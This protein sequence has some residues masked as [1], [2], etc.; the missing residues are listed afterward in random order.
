MFYSVDDAGFVSFNNDSWLQH[1][2]KR[3]MG[4]EAQLVWTKIERED[5]QV[6]MFWGNDRANCPLE[7]RFWGK[8][9]RAE[10][11]SGKFPDPH[12][13][14]QVTTCSGYDL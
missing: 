7:Q 12:A 9:V 14:L 5:C 11:C 13:G 4:R 2:H 10:E 8:I 1:T 3:P 6:G